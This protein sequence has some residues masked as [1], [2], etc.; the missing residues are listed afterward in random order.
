ML[1][2]G[3]YDEVPPGV[4][5]YPGSVQERGSAPGA[6]QSLAMSPQMSER[7]LAAGRGDAGGDEVVDPP[8]GHTR[9]MLTPPT[10]QHMPL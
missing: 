3:P 4:T 6:Q 10:A 1:R 8:P 7:Q 9:L 5:L 2:H